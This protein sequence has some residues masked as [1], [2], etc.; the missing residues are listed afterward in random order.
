MGRLLDAYDQARNGLLP[1]GD[2][3]HKVL[4]PATLKT[5]TQ[6]RGTE[7]QSD[8]CFQHSVFCQTGLARGC[9]R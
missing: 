2:V 4:P 1:L 8:I 6:S 3:A 5:P 9:S 7:D